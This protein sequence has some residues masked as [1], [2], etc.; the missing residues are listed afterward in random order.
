MKL[1]AVDATEKVNDQRKEMIAEFE[2][3]SEAVM[4]Q[5]EEKKKE[6]EDKLSALRSKY[7]LIAG[8]EKLIDKLK[9]FIVSAKWTYTESFGIVHAITHLDEAKAR[10]VK[11]GKNEFFITSG[12]LD[13]I[14]YFLSKKE[15]INFGEAKDFSE[16]IKPILDMVPQIEA[17]MA[18]LQPYKDIMENL[19]FKLQALAQ[20]IEP[21]NSIDETI[22]DH[23]EKIKSLEEVADMLNKNTTNNG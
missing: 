11:D 16:M 2:A 10:I 22:G 17:D 3:K 23:E 7:Y 18:S 1:E 6:F 5:L 19:K 4:A 12:E 20:R 15:G 21:D 13:P 14:T 8:G 9:K